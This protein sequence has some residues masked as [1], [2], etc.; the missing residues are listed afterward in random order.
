MENKYGGCALKEW[1]RGWI[2]NGE[3][4]RLEIN[5]FEH[6]EC[7]CVLPAVL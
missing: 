2:V 7:L 4:G 6:N 5:D 1:E 3:E